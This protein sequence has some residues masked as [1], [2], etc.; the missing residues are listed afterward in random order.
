MSRDKRAFEMPATPTAISPS[1]QTQIASTE[2]AGDSQDNGM[3][4]PTIGRRLWWRQA[5]CCSLLFVIGHMVGNLQVFL[6]P[7]VFNAYGE[8]LRMFPA[9]LWVAR[10]GIAL[11]AIVHIVATLRLAILNLR[12]VGCL[13]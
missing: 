10:A 3:W 7:D 12:R 6:G 9:L 8:K 11:A 13:R 4:A 5:A 1:Q 2:A